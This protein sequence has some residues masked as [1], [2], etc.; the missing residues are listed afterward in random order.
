MG[1]SKTGKDAIAKVERA[2][3]ALDMRRN[4]ANYREIAD[5]L[6]VGVGTIHRDVSQALRALVA[7]QREKAAEL[8]EL[9]LDRLDAIYEAAWTAED[10]AICLRVIDQQAKLVGLEAPQQTEATVKVVREDH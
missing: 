3:T 7:E 2:R 8:L 1:R 4:G 9:S 5:R 6:G 10:Y